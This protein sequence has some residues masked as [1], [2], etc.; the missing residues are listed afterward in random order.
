MWTDSHAMNP[1]VSVIVASYNQSEYIVQAIDSVLGQTYEN[2][3]IIVVDNGS[4]DRSRSL[5][6]QYEG[7]RNVRLIFHEKNIHVTTKLNQCIAL[8]RGAY[9]AILNGDDYCLPHKI[10]TEVRRLGSLSPDYGVAYSCP[11]RLYVPNGRKER[12]RGIL[13]ESGNVLPS[14]LSFKNGFVELVPALIRKECFSRYRFYD[15]L[16]IEGEAIFWRIALTYKFA[17]IDE[18]L[19]VLR[20]HERNIGKDFNCNFAPTMSALERLA[21]LPEFPMELRRDLKHLRGRLLRNYGWQ[22]IRVDANGLMAR[23]RLL[24][25][26]ALSWSQIFCPRIWL[27]LLLSW[28]PVNSLRAFNAMA[29]RI[30]AVRSLARG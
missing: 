29:T 24:C 15:D 17:Y 30:I 20:D 26:L 8:A 5:I 25:A 19:V 18:P 6:Q 28:L 22:S 12:M 14:L 13:Q 23:D 27:G 1:L 11:Y 2:V 21:Q 10:E 16:F 4:T 7:R 3:E 9:V